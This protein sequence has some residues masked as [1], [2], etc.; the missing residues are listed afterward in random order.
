MLAAFSKIKIVIVGVNCNVS[1]V[2]IFFLNKRNKLFQIGL[3][4]SPSPP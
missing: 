1:D 3:A 2:V 4:K